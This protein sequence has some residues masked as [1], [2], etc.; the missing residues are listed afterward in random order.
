MCMKVSDNIDVLSNQSVT[1][2]TGASSGIGLHL[3]DLLAKN[4]QNI[5]VINRNENKTIPILEELLAKYPSTRASYLISDLSDQNEILKLSGY[6]KQKN[7]K[8]DNLIN[9]AGVL[10]L[11]RGISKQG[12]ELTF[13]VNHIAPYLLSTQLYNN[14][15]FEKNALIL[16][17]NSVAH[18]KA[19]GDFDVYDSNDYQNL[20][21]IQLYRESKLANLCTTYILAD[22]FKNDDIL[23]NAIHPG[24]VSTGL[25]SNY[26]WLSFIKYGL[27]L[28][29]KSPKIAA[30]ETM[31]V[32]LKCK[33]ER[34][35]SEYF[36][37]G[38]IVNS[39]ENSY[40]KDIQKKIYN[41]TIGLT[42]SIN[43]ENN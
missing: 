15:M 34:I 14:N 35:T 32:I 1:I 39:S 16:N 27:K 8:I 23:V 10:P 38:K 18:Y 11:K 29:G 25:L 40:D 37:E 20:S 2:L 41:I 28:Y 6:I 22:Q 31:E 5:L 21:R 19:L 24:V 42:N 33:S 13:A 30:K 4:Y 43:M 3:L 7:I 26:G 36:S 9:N 17:N 12:I